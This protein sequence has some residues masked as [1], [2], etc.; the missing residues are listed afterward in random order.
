MVGF[1]GDISTSK[2]NAI[3]KHAKATVST[4]TDQNGLNSVYTNFANQI[5]SNFTVKNINFSETFPNNVDIVKVPEGFTK[6]G[7]TVTGVINNLGYTLVNGRFQLNQPVSFE[8]DLKFNNQGAYI[9]SQS[10]TMTYTDLYNV[11]SSKNFNNINVQVN[12]AVTKI[13]KIPIQFSR[14]IPQSQY[15]LFKR[16]N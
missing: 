11:N 15:N 9:I 14:S 6:N 8:I 10:S 13:S 16:A 4:A 1:T 5:L 7:Q 2:L 3:G 12:S